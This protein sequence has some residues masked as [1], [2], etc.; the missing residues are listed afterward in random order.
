MHLTTARAWIIGALRSVGLAN[1]RADGIKI[2]G[3]G[4]L[5]KKLSVSAHAFSASAKAKIEAKGGTCEVVGNKKAETAKRLRHA[6]FRSIIN[7][8]GNCFK[9]PELKSRI[10]FTIG[11]LTVCRLTAY[12]RIPG[13]DG[14]MLNQAMDEAQRGGGSGALSLLGAFS[15]R[16]FAELRDWRPHDHSLHQR[17]NHTAIVDRSGA[18]VEQRWPGKKMAFVK[19]IQYG[20]YLTVLLCLG[21]GFL[22]ALGYEHPESVLQLKLPHQLILYPDSWIWCYRIQTTIIVTCGTMLPGCGWV[23][24]LPTAA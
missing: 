8:F 21:Q 7:T 20:R 9:I 10:L 23:N 12:I 6:M 19:I 15:G 18:A 17:N 2:L 4:E 11:M 3:D 5:T 13:L 24:K 14:G 22:T 16:R 1:G